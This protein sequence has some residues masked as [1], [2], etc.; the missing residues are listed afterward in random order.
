MDKSEREI[1]LS[2]CIP[3]L[4]EE[5]ALE[6]AVQD[7]SHTL[8]PVLDKLEIIIVNDGS[9]DS[10]GRI[11][12]KLAKESSEVKVIHHSQKKGLGVC[13]KD[14]LRIAGGDYFT[15]F[16]GD[17]ENSAA[18]LLDAL[19]YL[20]ENT[21]VTTHHVGSDTRSLFRIFLSRTYTFIINTVF[22]LKVKYYNGLTILPTTTA[23]SFD[24]VSDGFT[25]SAE[26]LIR[27]IKS[28]CRLIELSAPLQSREGG[29]SKALTPASV[30]QMLKDV[31]RIILNRKNFLFLFTSYIFKIL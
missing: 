3:A 28:G 12:E 13:Y 29:S 23:K 14:A 25:W 26:N 5:K 2:V 15:W 6:E 19:G 30:K 16:P 22:G 17:H 9:Q 1:K 20:E 7:L 31:W 11:A 4:N 18:E 27:A 24:I 10:T 8:R 21:A